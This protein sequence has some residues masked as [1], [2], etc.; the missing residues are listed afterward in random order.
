MVGA[1]TTRTGSDGRCSL[2][3]ASERAQCQNAH[4]FRSPI[5]LPRAIA[6]VVALALVADDV[7]RCPSRSPR[8]RG[9]HFSHFGMQSRAAAPCFSTSYRTVLLDR[10]W[11]YR[12][13]VVPACRSI[14][15]GETS[16]STATGSDTVVGWCDVPPGAV[17]TV[18]TT[19][20]DGQQAK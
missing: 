10:Q 5:P 16:T 17:S 12:A 6:T 1:V 4:S 13:A 15:S 7:V 3:L 20:R 14:M 19:V 9:T 8:C 18:A 11:L 2:R